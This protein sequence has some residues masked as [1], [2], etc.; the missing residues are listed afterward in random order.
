LRLPRV[1]HLI[2]ILQKKEGINFQE[3]PLTIGEARRELLRL[4]RAGA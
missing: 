1:G 2:E 4:V 3:M